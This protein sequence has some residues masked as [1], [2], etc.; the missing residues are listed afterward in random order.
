MPE[1]ESPKIYL[2]WFPIWPTNSM[3]FTTRIMQGTRITE[4]RPPRLST[5]TCARPRRSIA[6]SPALGK[7]T[8]SSALAT[9]PP[10]V[11]RS[12]TAAAW[13]FWHTCRTPASHPHWP[14][15]RPSCSRLPR[16]RARRSAV[17][18]VDAGHRGNERAH[19]F[20]RFAQPLVATHLREHQ[21]F[22]AP[23]PAQDHR[24][25]DPHARRPPRLHRLASTAVRAPRMTGRRGCRGLWSWS[26]S[27]SID[28]YSLDFQVLSGAGLSATAELQQPRT[29]PR[30]L[31]AQTRAHAATQRRAIQ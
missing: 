10:R 21:R 31:A 2:V 19:V 30:A 23:V 11:H 13:R 27:V 8:I 26:K 6:S 16:P 29:I 20:L 24:P 22:D 1:I 17:R 18:I 28:R 3:S 25:V 5:S 9:S 12:S 7:A 4:G 15:S 14:P